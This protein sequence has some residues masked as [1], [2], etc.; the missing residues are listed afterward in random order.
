MAFVAVTEI[1]GRVLRPLIRLRQQ[2]AVVVALVD[3]PAELPQELVGFGQVLAVGAV[4]FEQVRDGVEPETVNAAVQ[5][6]VHCLGDGGAN[7]R[8]VE[9][10]VRLVRVEAV[11]VVRASHRIPCPVRGLEVIEDDSSVGIAVGSVAPNVEVAP[12][13][14]GSCAS[15][16]LEPRVLV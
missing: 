1:G 14:A 12:G 11:P 6:E 13:T 2:H 9:V 5:P 3:V 16:P 15:G 7:S 10:Q 8:V 4:A